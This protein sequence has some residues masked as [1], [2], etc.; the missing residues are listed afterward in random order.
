MVKNAG[1]GIVYLNDE[2]FVIPDKGIHI[3]GSPW[4][5]EFGAWAFNGQ[6]G[7]FLKSK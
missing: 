4:S 5:P 3:W 2:S 6:R 1:H 7:Q